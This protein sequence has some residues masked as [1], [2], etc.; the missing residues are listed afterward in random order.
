MI[1]EESGWIGLP[2]IWNNSETDAF[3]DV[4]GGIK[5][6]SWIDSKVEEMKKLNID[7][8]T[9]PNSILKLKGKGLPGQNSGRRGD[10]YVR[11]V[12]EIPKKI[13]KDKKNLLNQFEESD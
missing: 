10:Q 7:S 1:H 8:G 6:A 13:S 2:Y 4:A 12:V 5:E 9:Q 3:L 11:V